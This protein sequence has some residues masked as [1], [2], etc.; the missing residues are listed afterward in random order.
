MQNQSETPKASDVQPESFKAQLKKLSSQ[1]SASTSNKVANPLALVNPD[2]KA[3]GPKQ[4]TSAKGKKRLSEQ[5]ADNKNESATQESAT[6]EAPQTATKVADSQ[7]S[8]SGAA[9]KEEVSSPKE[10]ASSKPPESATSYVKNM[11]VAALSINASSDS[12]LPSSSV[13]EKTAATSA[14]ATAPTGASHRGTLIQLG[15]RRGRARRFSRCGRK[16]RI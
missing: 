11:D 5:D 1:A 8:N 16:R 6:Q 15:W 4:S 9:S 14:A 3:Q 12:S 10:E 13:I 2:G 7:T